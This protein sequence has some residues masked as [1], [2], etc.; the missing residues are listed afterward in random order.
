M[1]IDQHQR[2]TCMCRSLFQE[3]CM[4]LEAKPGIKE[5]KLAALQIPA[6][7]KANEMQHTLRLGSW[8]AGIPICQYQRE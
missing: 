7:L 2:Y 5:Y 6:T 4:R 8:A 3:A 1:S